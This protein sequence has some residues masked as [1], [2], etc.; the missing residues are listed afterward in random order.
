M[1]LHEGGDGAVSVRPGHDLRG[2]WRHDPLTFVSIVLLGLSALASIGFGVFR[3]RTIN[4]FVRDGELWEQASWRTIGVGWGGLLLTRVALIGL[5]GGAFGCVA[6]VDPA[7][8]CGH[9][10]GSDAQRG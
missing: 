10:G 7:H 4:L 9:F 8:D 2:T 3:G 5:G 6:N 1:L